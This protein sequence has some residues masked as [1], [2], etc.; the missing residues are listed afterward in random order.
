[1]VHKLKDKSTQLFKI[2]RSHLRLVRAQE[3]EMKQVT[4]WGLIRC[5][6]KYLVAAAWPPV[7]VD[8]RNE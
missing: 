5:H 1:M 2:S 3:G 8:P 6:H 7:F 4:Y